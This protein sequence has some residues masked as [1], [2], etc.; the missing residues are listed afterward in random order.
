MDEQGALVGPAS[1]R[2][3]VA[4]L[5][6]LALSHPRPISRDRLIAFLWPERDSEHARN[7]LKQGVHALRK[8]FGEAAIASAGDEL[9]LGAEV[10]ACD[11]VA[12]EAALAAVSSRDED[13]L[14]EAADLVFHL[15][16]LLRARGLA[17]GDVV[18]VLRARHA[19]NDPDR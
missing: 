3:R 7:L 17:I 2:H 18:E 9:Y 6:L 14:G 15:I 4:L 16:V 13:L 19:A 5:A 12:F 1:Q 11:V 10:V 8:A